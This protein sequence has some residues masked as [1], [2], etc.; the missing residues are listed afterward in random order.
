MKV[1]L[2]PIFA[3]AIIIVTA[4]MAGTASFAADAEHGK[5]LYEKSCGGCHDT[6][7]HTRPNRIVHTYEDLVNR[8]RFCD[9]AAKANFS[10]DD[11]YDVADYLNDNFYKFIKVKE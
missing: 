8:I 10:E 4:S 2:N 5:K 1:K 7:V 9:T 11:I 3:S 6:K